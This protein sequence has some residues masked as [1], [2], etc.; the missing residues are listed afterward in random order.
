MRYEQATE[1][2]RVR[3]EPKFSLA[4]SDPS[5]GTFVFSYQVSLA[6]ESC[7]SGTGGSTTRWVRTLSWTVTG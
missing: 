7:C 4:E 2:I 3:V 1:G 5:Q 6:N